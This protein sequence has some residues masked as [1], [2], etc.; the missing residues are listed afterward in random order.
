MLL[1]FRHPPLNPL[2]QNLHSPIHTHWAQKSPT[3][4]DYLF[5][6]VERGK[7]IFVEIQTLKPHP[8]KQEK[9]AIS[10]P[11]VITVSS[12]KLV[13]IR[14]LTIGTQ[15]IG[16]WMLQPPHAQAFRLMNTSEY[17][18]WLVR[19]MFLLHIVDHTCSW[20]AST[21]T[22]NMNAPSPNRLAGTTTLPYTVNLN[23]ESSPPSDCQSTMCPYVG[24][25]VCMYVCM[26]VC[27][28]VCVY[29]CMCVCM[30]V[31]MYVCMSVC[32]YVYTYIYIHLYVGPKYPCVSE[33]GA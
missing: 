26:Y 15:Q 16:N 20:P 8:H 32:T 19:P 4:N 12:F 9:D 18:N 17:I 33:R 3:S 31:C 29:V 14:L 13:L 11:L 23:R 21:S 28:Y 2:I 25:Y 24:T 22:E 7:A 5:L 27:V 30:Y 10:F 1:A 6:L